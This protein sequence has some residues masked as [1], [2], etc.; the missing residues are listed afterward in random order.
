MEH[1][2]ETAPARPA[3]FRTAFAPARGALT[4]VRDVV[5]F[6][7]PLFYLTIA[8]GAIAF[9]AFFM[10]R[11]RGFPFWD[12]SAYENQAYLVSEAFSRSFGEGFST[13]AASLNEDYNLVQT[14][15]VVPF[16][17]FFGETRFVY[18]TAVWIVY[19]IPFTLVC[20]AIGRRMFPEH[21]AQ[22]GTV[23]ALMA[24][25]TPL[26]WRN[27]LQG[28]PDLGG[29][30]L[31]GVMLLLYDRSARGLRWRPLIAIGVA[32]AC[33]ILFRRHFVY[34]A[35]AF[36]V[37]FAADIGIASWRRGRSTREI[38]R[39][40]AYLAASG[41]TM[42]AVLFLVAPGFVTRVAS[43]SYLQGFS[44]WEAA[45]PIIA[46]I[47]VG[48]VGLLPFGV[49]LLGMLLVP[50][51][52]GTGRHLAQV[53]LVA[54]VTW[55][56]VWV[57]MVRQG[58]THY[59]HVLPFLLIFGYTSLW[60]YLTHVV[61]REASR[62]A[63]AVLALA[64]AVNV[65]LTIP[66]ALPAVAVAR[67][68]PRFVIAD[69]WGG[70]VNPSYDQ[71]ARL[72][73]DLRART[74]PTDPIVVAAS[75]TT[76]NP[77]LLREAERTLV[78]LHEARLD[79]D[80]TPQVDSRDVSPPAA[81]LASAAYVIVADPF[82]HHLRAED[83]KV[84]S[85]LVDAFAQHWRVTRDFTALPER[86]ELADGATVTV[87]KRTRPDSLDVA[88]D[89]SAR[90]AAYM[91]GADTSRPIAVADAWVQVSSPYPMSLTAGPNGT[92]IV[93][94]PTAEGQTPNTEL[95]LIDQRDDDVRISGDVH[96]FDQRCIGDRVLLGTE[97]G[98]PR[99]TPA[100]EFKPGGL[101]HFD[102][103]VRHARGNP[104]YLRLAHTA[105][106]PTNI[107]Y[108][109]TRIDGL[110]VARA[111]SPLTAGAARR[112]ASSA[113][114]F[115]VTATAAKGASGA[116]ASPQPLAAVTW[117]KLPGTYAGELARQPDGTWVVSTHP[118]RRG[119][120]GPTILQAQG[121]D[122]DAVR[123]T[124]TLRFFSDKCVGEEVVAS[125]A[126]GD[127][128]PVSAGVF[129]PNRNGDPL[130]V[131]VRRT[132]DRPLQ[133]LLESTAAAPERIEFCATRIENL[134]V[135]PA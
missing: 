86:F 98:G 3:S 101:S 55:V 110:R 42:L 72:V 67:T 104:V 45:P 99:V 80:N 82:E 111:G 113:D 30:I 126:G 122:A 87:Y 92:T 123:V 18:I 65:M 14:A 135:S 4:W 81:D 52:T 66:V 75:S 44:A 117:T 37:G 5:F 121:I 8:L 29:S 1:S 78:G 36:Y 93:A 21:A 17:L 11:E 7:R 94:H 15:A 41:I 28:Y 131:T 46:A 64:L 103:T 69:S 2:L 85:A 100:G 97:Y 129:K 63:R 74:A 53:I 13:I 12:F 56:F 76:F 20:T 22:A 68:L 16:V 77:D 119:D 91:R 79:I 71:I 132:R 27:I 26:A 124:G 23:A 115:A 50:Q 6:G 120:P 51:V 9:Y 38:V 118:T 54:S 133:L 47:M 130:D 83:Q 19:F 33:A 48:T 96:F 73:Y 84:V 105:S 49:A 125:A 43:V 58:P 102:V 61:P 62:P 134:R 127:G 40:Y 107:Y 34:G 24:V 112:L 90:M 39:S 114:P 31:I 88:A 70:L 116:S 109:T 59:P 32:A 128:A 35:F 108:C 10:G 60:L 89:T 95:A 106:S 25:A 57:F